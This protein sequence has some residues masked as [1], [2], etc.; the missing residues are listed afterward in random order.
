MVDVRERLGASHGVIWSIVED[1]C[2][3]VES[4]LQGLVDGFRADLNKSTA[5]V[6][7]AGSIGSEFHAETAIDGTTLRFSDGSGS[8]DGA[9]STKGGVVYDPPADSEVI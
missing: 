7:R 6:F 5:D 3:S 4:S 8:D 9:G 2:A 1:S